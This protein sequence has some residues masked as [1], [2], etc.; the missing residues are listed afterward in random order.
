M[1]TDA[2]KLSCD[3]LQNII[4]IIALTTINWDFRI[5]LK[6]LKYGQETMGFMKID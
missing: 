6:L 3:M 5:H 4:A 2:I 1:G